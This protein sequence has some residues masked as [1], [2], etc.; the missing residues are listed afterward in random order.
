MRTNSMLF[1]AFALALGLGIVAADLPSAPANK[2]K[3]GALAPRLVGT[4]APDVLISEVCFN[5][6]DGESE[7]VELRN[8]SGKPFSI[9]GWLLTDEDG[10]DFVIPGNLPEMPPDAHVVIMFD[11]G[12]GASETDE[13]VRRKETQSWEDQFAKGEA[14]ILHTPADLGEDVFDD[15]SDQ[16]GLY[17]ARKKSV[18][19]IRDYVVWGTCPN[20]DSMI[21]VKAGIWRAKEYFSTVPGP[22]GSP[23]CLQEGGALARY[24]AVDAGLWRWVPVGPAYKSSGSATGI[25]PLYPMNP[26]PKQQSAT[27]KIEFWWRSPAP[28]PSKLFGTQIQV[29]RDPSFQAA[30]IDQ[31]VPYPKGSFI[32][33]IE[34]PLGTYYWRLRPQVSKTLYGPWSEVVEFSIIP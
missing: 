17:T 5:P 16:C 32:S 28:G 31:F 8:T 9:R 13:E 25:L 1:V 24:L 33:P 23:R 3:P 11:G 12:G 21:P 15:V 34:L 20:V 19:T 22:P 10:N 7:W 14:V 4:K 26:A 18:T 30:V 27:R 6:K 29:S 2:G